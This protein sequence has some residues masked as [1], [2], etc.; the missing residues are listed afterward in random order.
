M[1]KAISFH[2]TDFCHSTYTTELC[3]RWDQYRFVRQCKAFDYSYC[4]G[5]PVFSGWLRY[6]RQHFP[7]PSLWLQW[8]LRL[9]R[10]QRLRLQWLLRLSR[11][12]SLRL[13]WLLRRA[14]LCCQRQSIG[15][16]AGWARLTDKSVLV[17]NQET[18]PELAWFV[19]NV[20]KICVECCS[21]TKWHFHWIMLKRRRNPKSAIL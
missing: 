15:I 7:M 18:S 6:N 2:L 19:E 13:Q 10:L 12:R 8:L 9:A 1:L 17:C 14:C 3:L 4:F 11:L 5:L 21:R 16:R 20:F